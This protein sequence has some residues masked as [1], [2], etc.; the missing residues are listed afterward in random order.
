MRASSSSGTPSPR[1][2]ASTPSPRLRARHEA[3]VR[4]PR[5]EAAAQRVQ[6]VAPVRRDDEREVAGPRLEAM[7]PST[8]TT[9]SPSSAPIRRTAAGDRRLADDEHPRRGQHGLE[10]D[11]DRAAR[12]ARVLDGDGALGVGTTS[13]ARVCPRPSNGRIRSST[14]S[15]VS[16]ACS[17]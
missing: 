4:H 11:L 2:S 10:E 5:L 6:L 3:D 16:I 14:A 13:A 8:P 12:Q 15:P 1:S 17:E 9:S 7:P